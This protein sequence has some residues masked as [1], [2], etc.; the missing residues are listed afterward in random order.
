MTPTPYRVSFFSFLVNL[1]LRLTEEGTFIIYYDIPVLCDSSAILA[2]WEHQRAT[3]QERVTVWFPLEYRHSILFFYLYSTKIVAL[4]INHPIQPV[5]SIL[6][7]STDSTHRELPKMAFARDRQYIRGWGN[8]K[9]DSRLP[10]QLFYITFLSF[11]FF[12]PTLLPNQ[13]S[14]PRLDYFLP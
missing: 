5:P 8:R 10:G 11:S 9:S 2:Q 4:T 12:S 14:P 3:F 13:S 7:R 1:G 6:T